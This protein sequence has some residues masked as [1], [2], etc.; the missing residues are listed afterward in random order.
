MVSSPL[1]MDFDTYSQCSL[2]R[3]HDLLSLEIF[4]EAATAEVQYGKVFGIQAGLG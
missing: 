1:T 4:S 2:S 3:S